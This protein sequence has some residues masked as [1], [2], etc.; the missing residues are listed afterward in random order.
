LALV[1]L[2]L[3]SMNA[4]AEAARDAQGPADIALTRSANFRP[5]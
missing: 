5:D 2:I 3:V 1:F 4:M